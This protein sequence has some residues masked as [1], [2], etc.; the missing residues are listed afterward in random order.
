MFRLICLSLCFIAIQCAIHVSEDCEKSTYIIL[1]RLF[2]CETKTGLTR[3]VVS[4]NGYETRTSKHAREGS[5]ETYDLTETEPTETSDTLLPLPPPPKIISPLI[6][7]SSDIVDRNGVR[8]CIRENKVFVVNTNRQVYTI[9]LGPHSTYT[10][11]TRITCKSSEYVPMAIGINK[12]KN[13]VYILASPIGQC[14]QTGGLFAIDTNQICFNNM[15]GQIAINKMEDLGDIY[16]W[17]AVSEDDEIHLWGDDSRL[18]LNPNAPDPCGL[19]TPTPTP[20]P[21][22][23]GS[24]RTYRTW[25]YTKCG[26]C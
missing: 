1:N 2:V 13:I 26:T 15:Y 7:S 12:Q 24:Y 16:K 25:T 19:E 3:S 10:H 22:P 23:Y 4:C 6:I 21:R 18:I 20:T 5:S 9:V 11:Y 14:P 8:F 17:L